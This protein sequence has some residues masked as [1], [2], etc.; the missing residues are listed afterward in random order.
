MLVR[1]DATHYGGI[2]HD[3]NCSNNGPYTNVEKFIP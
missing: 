1:V 3:M 2:R